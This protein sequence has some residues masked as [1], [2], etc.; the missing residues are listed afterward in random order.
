MISEKQ[1]FKGSSDTWEPI[2]VSHQPTKFGSP[3]HC[4][5]GNMCL[6]V[7]KQDFTCSCL[8]LALLIFFKSIWHDGD[9]PDGMLCLHIRNFT[10][11]RTLTKTFAS[12]SN[13]ITRS[14]SHASSVTKKN[15]PWKEE[16]KKEKNSNGKAFC[17]THKH[18]KLKTNF[19]WNAEEQKI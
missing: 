17:V 7:E 19:G 15:S 5:G 10:I 4:I 2:M 6:V 9:L 16:K 11:K 1:V 12:V 18:N 14:C 3:R 13:E 8:I